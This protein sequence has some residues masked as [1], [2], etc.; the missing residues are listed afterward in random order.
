MAHLACKTHKL[1]VLVFKRDVLPVTLH[2]KDGSYCNNSRIL[3]LG[4]AT[5]SPKQVVHNFDGANASRTSPEQQLL[6]EIFEK[7]SDG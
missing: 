6:R 7:P 1:R 4:E 2:R 3:T 5:W